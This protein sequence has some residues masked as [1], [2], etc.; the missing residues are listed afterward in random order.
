MGFVLNRVNISQHTRIYA[1]TQGHTITYT[2]PTIRRVSLQK[3]GAQ[4]LRTKYGQ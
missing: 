2:I 1:R 4:K 3:R